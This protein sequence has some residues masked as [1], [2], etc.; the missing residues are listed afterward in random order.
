MKVNREIGLEL[1]ALADGQLEGQPMK[2]AERL[3]ESDE[4]AH[5]LIARMSD[6]RTK[7]WLSDSME[8][9]AVRAGADAIAESVLA[10]LR[11]SGGTESLS[12]VPRPASR[13]ASRVPRERGRAMA[14]T[15]TIAAVIALFV[16]YRA[17]RGT[18]SGVANQL[19]S[20]GGQPTT[21]A[22]GVELDEIDAPAHDVSVF[23]ISGAAALATNSP[24][25]SSVVIWIDD[26]P[27]SQ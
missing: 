10:Q 16:G 1:M 24:P 13:V 6:P 19:E 8:Q 3:A 2:H 26:E 18:G 4:R 9:R 20:V 22:R 17:S 12:R 7:A 27:G 21:A 25:G 14:V 5:A 23:E 11:V 15:L